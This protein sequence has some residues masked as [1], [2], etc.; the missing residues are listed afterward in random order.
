MFAALSRLV[1]SRRIRTL[2]PHPVSKGKNRRW[3][4]EVKT[5]GSQAPDHTVGPPGLL[6]R[7]PEGIPGRIPG[8]FFTEEQ[9]PMD[10]LGFMIPFRAHMRKL[11]SAPA[12]HHDR[13]KM[14]CYKD[15]DAPAIDSEINRR[16]VRHEE[17]DIGVSVMA[18]RR[19][20]IVI[21]QILHQRSL[22]IR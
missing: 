20:P 3:H 12:K 14:F 11:R 6:Q 7:R 19:T 21:I 18:A 16:K 10:H 5:L 2:P 8:E 13:R 9:A 22:T 1:G 4:R 15:F 17:L